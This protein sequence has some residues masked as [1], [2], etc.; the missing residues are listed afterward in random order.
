MR[1]H[2]LLFACLLTLLLVVN[3]RLYAQNLTQA[4]AN[5]SLHAQ[6]LTQVQANQARLVP[7][8]VEHPFRQPALVGISCTVA[9]FRAVRHFWHPDG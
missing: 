1:R 6:N 7:S 8:D 4:Q 9:L 3:E 2:N 5:Q